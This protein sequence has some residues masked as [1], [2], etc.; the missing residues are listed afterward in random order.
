MFQQLSPGLAVSLSVNV[1]GLAY[2]G[3]FGLKT[4][5]LGHGLSTA[6]DISALGT[7]WWLVISLN[8]VNCSCTECKV[9]SGLTNVHLLLPPSFPLS[10]LT[11]LA[12]Q[13]LLEMCGY[14]DKK[15]G[16]PTKSVHHHVFS[17]VYIKQ[18][19]LYYVPWCIKRVFHCV[20]S[21]KEQFSWLI[22]ILILSLRLI[23]SISLWGFKSFSN[24]T[25]NQLFA[26]ATSRKKTVIIAGA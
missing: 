2:L 10:Q 5:L 7:E 25:L 20:Q 19:I 26:M 18:S 17:V 21:A 9:R 1:L 22:G 16:L 13:Y 8:I 6:A 11:E 12:C 3:I 14:S 24:A 23:N 15:K 4:V